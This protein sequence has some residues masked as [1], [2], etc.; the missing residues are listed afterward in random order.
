MENIK[1]LPKCCWCGL[2]TNDCM[3]S[4]NLGTICLM[5]NA[6]NDPSGNT[7]CHGF[8]INFADRSDGCQLVKAA[9]NFSWIMGYTETC[10][11]SSKTTT[12]KQEIWIFQRTDDLLS[13]GIHGW[14]QTCMGMVSVRGFQ[15][16]TSVIIRGITNWSN[17]LSDTHC[18]NRGIHSSINEIKGSQ[19]RGFH[20]LQRKTNTKIN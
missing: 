18:G 3:H 10:N 11:L 2:I 16:V 13:S 20:V 14:I 12:W 4:C 17:M 8:N 15:F 6:T 1:Y 7:L 9:P 19:S 5:R